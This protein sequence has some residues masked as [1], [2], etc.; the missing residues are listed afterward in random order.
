LKASYL[1]NNTIHLWTE[2][3]LDP[4]VYIPGIC[5]AGQYGLTAPGPCSTIGN[6]QA[7]RALTQ[8]N[9]AQGPYYGTL[10]YLDDG[11]TA[12]YNAFLISAE[13]RLGNNFFLLANYTWSHCI[14]DP[15]TTGLGNGSYTNPVNRRF[16][17]GNCTAVDV[18]HNLNLS[19]VV[20]S[21]HYS[22]PALQRIL[23]DW[24]LAPIAVLRSGSFFTITSG[25][26]SAL[27]GIAG[28]RPN[29]V[30]ADPYCAHRSYTCWLNGL[31]FATPPNGTFGNVGVNS[32]MGPGYFDVDL[33]LSRRFP[34][35]EK[36][37]L[38]LRAEAF[39]IENRVNFLNPSNP[40]YVGNASG[41]VLNNSNFGKILSD[42]SPRIMQFAVKY[43]F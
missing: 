27:N 28:Q 13:H 33:A 42:V 38:E 35:K 32:L 36:Q 9:P 40:G 34:L 4:A 6:T 39:N 15:Q 24:E 12:S 43:Y 10:R 26:D 25:V 11:G 20:Q 3:E 14:A 19:A 17:R 7:R 22:K 8:L 31:A 30:L 1:G 21:P 5:A 41:S 2:R 23:G 37:Y 16:D 29:Q 18:R